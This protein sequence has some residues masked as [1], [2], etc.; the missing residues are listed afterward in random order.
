M[1][2]LVVAFAVLRVCLKIIRPV[3]LFSD[4]LS[5]VFSCCVS[6]QLIFRLQNRQILSGL[7]EPFYCGR[8]NYDT[9]LD[10][11]GS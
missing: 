5:K 6:L 4:R 1:T 7:I 3:N 8:L 9:F 2:K 11:T 10:C